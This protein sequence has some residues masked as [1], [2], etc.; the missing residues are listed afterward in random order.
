MQLRVRNGAIDI[1]VESINS[2]L[3]VPM[4]GFDLMRDEA[5]TRVLDI[6]SYFRKQFPKK[7]KMHPTDV[8]KLITKSNELGIQFKINFLVVFANIMVASRTMG[9]CN[10]QFLDK[11]SNEDMMS[12][13][14]WCQY[15]YDMLKHSKDGWSR[16]SLTCS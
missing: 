9:S 1:T 13:I 14:N 8:M 7:P 3:G 15:I 6:A 2:I 11:I 16:S 5:P 4:C 12:R 10:L